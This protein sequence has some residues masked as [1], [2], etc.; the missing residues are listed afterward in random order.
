MTSRS[1]GHPARSTVTA[2]RICDQLTW[3]DSRNRAGQPRVVN[4]HTSVGVGGPSDA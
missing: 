1:S 4:R 3:P 2:A